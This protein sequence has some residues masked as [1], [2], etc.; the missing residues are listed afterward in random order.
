MPLLYQNVNFDPTGPYWVP[1]ISLFR[2][3]SEPP[4]TLPPIFPW[5]SSPTKSVQ[6]PGPGQATSTGSKRVAVVAARACC[7]S[8]MLS[9]NIYI[10][11]LVSIHVPHSS[12]LH[13]SLVPGQELVR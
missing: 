6:F 11:G 13:R 2:N 8:A 1:D 7:V 4:S 12:Q 5:T 9:N 10:F 3:L